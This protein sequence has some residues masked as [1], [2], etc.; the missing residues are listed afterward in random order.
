MSFFL[1]PNFSH[2]RDLFYRSLILFVLVL[3]QLD[4]NCI[5]VVTIILMF[6]STFHGTV[7]TA[8]EP[9]LGGGYLI[10]LEHVLP[11]FFIVDVL[12]LL[13][14]LRYQ[15]LGIVICLLALLLDRALTSRN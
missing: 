7:P 14:L 5:F 3:D 10:V 9:L 15:I 2:I 6:L 11:D 4:R 13:T 12:G 1:A 8:H